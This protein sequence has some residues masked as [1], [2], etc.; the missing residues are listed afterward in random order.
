MSFIFILLSMLSANK[1]ISFL[2]RIIESEYEF[3][4]FCVGGWCAFDLIGIADFGEG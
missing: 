4:T 2:F 3:T 1:T